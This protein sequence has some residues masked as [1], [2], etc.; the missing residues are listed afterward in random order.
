MVLHTCERC[1]RSFN[2]KSN[3]DNHIK[4]KNQCD[5]IEYNLVIEE[6]EKKYEC[7]KCNK[8]FKYK[9]CLVKHLNG[10][11]D[12]S[13]KVI[14]N[15]AKQYNQNK[16]LDNNQIK[17]IEEIGN[18]YICM[19]CDKCFTREGNMNRHM[20]ICKKILNIDKKVLDILIKK[21]NK[22]KLMEKEMKKIKSTGNINN[23]VN[24]NS[25]NINN[26][27]NTTNNNNIIIQLVQHG[28]EDITKIDPLIIQN[29][30]KSGYDAIPNLIKGIHF[31]ENYPENQNIYVTNRRTDD[32]LIYNGHDWI[33]SSKEKVLGDLYDKKVEI[34][35][36]FKDDDENGYFKKLSASQ[37]KSLNRFINSNDNKEDDPIDAKKIKKIMKD[38]KYIVYNNRNIPM[39]HNIKKLQ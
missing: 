4:K 6:N 29:A 19:L 3:Y 27:F 39:K 30:L 25:N 16:Q 13:K 1:N 5:S 31:N 35:E 28:K 2:R 34:L 20:E 32:V 26:T 24:N 17:Q 11:K 10:K 36:E 37:Q 33:V 7:T 15:S 12:C 22:C 38:I 23:I 8:T 21:D 18:N 14:D 9:Y